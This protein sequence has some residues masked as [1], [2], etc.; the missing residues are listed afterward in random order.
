MAGDT[1]LVRRD[2]ETNQQHKSYAAANATGRSIDTKQGTNTTRRR[3]DLVPTLADAPEPGQIRRPKGFC[4]RKL[5]TSTSS[6][7]WPSQ[8]VSYKELQICR[9]PSG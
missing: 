9:A 7:I 6:H 4:W 3:D 8:P 2:T 5:N 1:T